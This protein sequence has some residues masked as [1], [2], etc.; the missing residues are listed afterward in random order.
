M[1]PERLAEIKA[2]LAQPDA[3]LSLYLLEIAQEICAE[4]ER[5][6]EDQLT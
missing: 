3:A 2:A 6:R 1:S 5:M 4:V